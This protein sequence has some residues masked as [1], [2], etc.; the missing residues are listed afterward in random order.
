MEQRTDKIKP[1]A[2]QENNDLQQRLEKQ[3]NDA[4]S[5]NNNINNIKEMLTY[6]K[7]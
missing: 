5:F 4:N 1:S 7:D 2:P 6:F 3:L